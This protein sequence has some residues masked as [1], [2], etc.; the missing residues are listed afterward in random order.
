MHAQR[1]LIRRAARLASREG[2]SSGL[3]YS[4]RIQLE[5]QLALKPRATAPFH[6][7][8]RRHD[9]L[10]RSPYQIF[11]ETLKDEL[12]K[13]KELQDN[14][15]QL[16]GDVDKF[17]DTESMK[18]AKE[19]YERARLTSSIRENPRLRAAAEEL[20]KQGV[21]VGDAVGEALKA[22][23]ESEW[24][25]GLAKAS[26]AVASAAATATAPV[27][28]TEAY[29]A[30]ADTVIDALDDSGSSKYGG[31][32]EKEA[33]RKRR[34]RR[35]QKA[36]RGGGL[37]ARS[38]RV[39]ANNDALGVV[40]H[41]NNEKDQKWERLKETNPVLRT[42]VDLR[43]S[44]DES[45]NPLV[46][47]VRSVT[48]KIG[49]L[50]EENET[51]QVV[52]AFRALDPSFDMEG[53]SREL[54]EYIVPEVV[55]AYLTA[56]KE[57]LKMWCGEAT[58][59]VLWATMEQ[60]AR[61]G[62]ISESRV[63]DIKHVEIA[64]GK[65]LED[66]IPVLTVTFATQE[67]LVFRNAKTG[68]I[69]VGA[70]DKVEQCMYGAVLTRV[71]SELDNPTTGGWKVIE[72]LHG[73]LGHKDYLFQKRLAKRVPMDSCRFDFRGNHETGGQWSIGGLTADVEDIKAV[74]A[75]LTTT[76]RYTVA[77]VIGHSRGSV[78]GMKWTSSTSEG[79][80]ILGFVNVAGRYRMEKARAWTEVL[81]A[82]E[83]QKQGFWVWSASVAGRQIQRKCYPHDLEEF[84]NWDTK[85]VVTD[86]PP[87][88]DVL[89][90]QGLADRIL[91][92][93]DGLLY[94]QGLSGR[95]GGSHTL[96]LI[97]EADHNFVG[98]HDEVVETILDWWD[99]RQRGLLKD[100]IWIP[101]D[102]TKM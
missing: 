87:R 55:D 83:I 72:I 4:S 66:E 30:L 41:K 25:R 16:Q 27:R 74:V 69:A 52:R 98:F 68:E 73:V 71:E 46:S 97:E 13:N 70:V 84:I 22:M 93:Y 7:S 86:F 77:L 59:N 32:E 34:E 35:L 78:A 37:A 80:S 17:Q 102:K 24:M 85:G 58:Y 62:L 12:R 28:N 38:G 14:V 20:K 21:K 63:L 36:G 67:V 44:Y 11:V 60:Y 61:Q 54:R 90:I 15:K 48:E 47:S 5:G 31:Y 8:S 96:H 99:R 56:D 64:T 79:R 57:A 50:F 89:S 92:P 26:S 65:I 42:F 75:Y 29:K 10:P 81:H 51:A 82:E 94:A 88:A 76:L 3:S 91:P 19:M 101:S 40:L 2:P 49:G 6:T 23:E 33:R 39:E 45:E 100:G 95:S 53:F 1:H 9:E 18:R 43:R